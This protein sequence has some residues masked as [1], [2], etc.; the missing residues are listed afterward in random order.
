MSAALNQLK[1]YPSYAGLLLAAVL[2][3]AL[4]LGGGVNLLFRPEGNS[5]N[6][7]GKGLVLLLALAAVYAVYRWYSKG[8]PPC[9]VGGCVGM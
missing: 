9:F 1:Q 3:L 2:S 5:L 4:L 6:M 7:V 8:V